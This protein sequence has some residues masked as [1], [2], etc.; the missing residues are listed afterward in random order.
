MLKLATTQ[1]LFDTYVPLV[2]FSI[3]REMLTERYVGLEVL[4]RTILGTL[5]CES[6]MWSPCW[7]T[8]PADALVR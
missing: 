6:R 8:H 5:A 7:N 3:S 1:R 4:S 2:H